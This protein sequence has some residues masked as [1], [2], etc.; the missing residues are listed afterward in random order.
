MRFL[1][2][3]GEH[4]PL[5]KGRGPRIN[6]LLGCVCAMQLKTGLH[7]EQEALLEVHH[8]GNF[9]YFL[10]SIFLW[11]TKVPA[12]NGLKV[13]FICQCSLGRFR[14]LKSLSICLNREEG[15]RGPRSRL[16]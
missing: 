7:G 1:C 5:M 8:N 16:Q 13:A 2:A 9:L 10:N 4:F 11:A 6:I 15:I 12:E 14:T 3:V